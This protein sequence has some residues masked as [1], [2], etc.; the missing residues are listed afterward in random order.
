[1]MMVNR[2]AMYFV[3]IV[4]DIED[5]FDRDDV[6]ALVLQKTYYD[7]PVPLS[8]K[9]KLAFPFLM[10]FNILMSCKLMMNISRFYMMILG[11]DI[12]GDG[13]H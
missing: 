1:M 11:T 9:K 8:P 4:H 7:L 12:W 10:N 2:K 6:G 5:T 3:D 13:Y